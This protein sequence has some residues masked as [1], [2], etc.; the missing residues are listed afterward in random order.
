V[1]EIRTQADFVRYIGKH[2][3]TMSVSVQ[4]EGEGEATTVIESHIGNQMAYEL[5]GLG[6]TVLFKKLD[7]TKTIESQLTDSLF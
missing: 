5:V 4:P 3:G 6:Y 2:A 7:P 1:Y